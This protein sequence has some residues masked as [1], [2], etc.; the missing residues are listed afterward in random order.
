MPRSEQTS[1]DIT[2]KTWTGHMNK[3]RERFSDLCSLNSMVRG[4]SKREVPRDVRNSKVRRPDKFRRDW[5][6]H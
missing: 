1:L 6:R 3:N 2:G 5:S 4:G